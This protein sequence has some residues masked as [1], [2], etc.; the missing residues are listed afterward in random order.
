MIKHLLSYFLFCGTMFAAGAAALTG[1][2]GGTDGAGAGAGASGTTGAGQGAGAGT[3]T[4]DTGQ[5]GGQQQQQQQQGQ[6]GGDNIRQLR[7]AYEGIKREIEP[8]QRLNLKPEQVS[9]YSGVYQKV[10]GE[11]ASIG[12]E[13]GY[14]DEEIAEAMAEDPVRT[15]DFLRNEVQR[16]QQGGQQQNQNGDLRDQ[17]AEVAQQVFAPIQERENLRATNEANALFE[18]TVHSEVTQIFKQEGIDVAN[19]PA[20][21]MFMIT[22]AASEIL[23]YDDAALRDLKYQGKTAPVQKAVREAVTLLDKYFLA[24]SGRAAARVQPGNR[25]GQGQQ[26][27]QQ[28][29]KRP[30]LDEMI[31]NPA[32]INAKY[33]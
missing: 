5:G 12:R 6:G 22:S 17:M 9:Q 8:W 27:Q 11:V 10:Y 2:G 28:G 24:R 30:S 32:L 7:E 26:Q 3:G 1:G 29:R 4:Q 16:I 20:D 19:I 18:R 21:E 13:L 14:P 15:L 25:G 33:V 31:D 23:K